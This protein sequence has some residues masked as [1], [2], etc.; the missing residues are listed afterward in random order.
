MGEISVD[1]QSASTV[2]FTLGYKSSDYSS[3]AAAVSAIGSTP[4]TL[5]IDKAETVTTDLT[6]PSTLSAIMVRPGLITVSSG[7]T[8]TINGPFEA[9]LYQIFSGSGSVVFGVMS[10]KEVYPEWWGAIPYT[11]DIAAC[12]SSAAFQKAVDS[13][14]TVFVS[15]G[16]WLCNFK[17]T[18]SNVLIR[19]NGGRSTR[20]FPYTNTDCVTIDSTTSSITNVKIKDLTLINE[21]IGVHTQRVNSNGLTITGPDTMHL[22]DNH[23]FADLLIKSFKNGINI[24]GRNIWSDYRNIVIDRSLDNG[25][26]CVTDQ[27]VNGLTLSNVFC[28]N[29]QHHGFYI[30]NTG[31]DTFTNW[32]FIFCDAESNGIDIANAKNSGFYCKNVHCFTFVNPHSEMNGTGSTDKLNYSMRFGGTYATNINIRGGVITGSE[33]GIVSEA[34]LSSGVIDNNDIRWN[35]LP[36]D[37]CYGIS[38]TGQYGD[39]FNARWNIPVSNQFAV[40]A[41]GQI[42]N[43]SNDVNG[44]YKHFANNNEPLAYWSDATTPA[45]L[46]LYYHTSVKFFVATPVT[47]N[48]LSNALPGQKVTLCG[49][50]GTADVTLSSTFMSEGRDF[51]IRAGDVFEFVVD[52][53]PD[54][55]KLILVSKKKRLI[56]ALSNSATPAVNDGEN[57][58]TGGTITITNLTGGYTG[59]V[60]R[61]ISEHAITI[62]DGTNIF[63]L[64]SANFVMK[65]TD[66]LTLI[67]KADGKWYELARSVN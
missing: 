15:E 7:K 55:G 20:I 9:P 23:C 3:L 27:A 4:A 39:T 6:F 40:P 12:D 21:T 41:N 52:G 54:E 62:T 32:T 50:Q 16:D 36:A 24:T 49:Y 46:D 14:K 19:G 65:A 64:G 18:K 42:F 47:I 31:A 10:V 59:Q 34:T 35:G 26:N 8:L 63:L 28:A 60:I 22:N 2:L 57:F 45:T 51:I 11:A 43:C 25:F 37:G 66:T 30:E 48:T 17:I 58:L 53:Y 5:Y 44:N 56:P 67:Q 29:S 61:I 38:L 33:G 13:E 1:I